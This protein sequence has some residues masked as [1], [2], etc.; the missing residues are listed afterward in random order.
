MKNLILSIF[1]YLTFFAYAQTISPI[2]F[3]FNK[4]S[5]FFSGQWWLVWVIY[6]GLDSLDLSRSARRSST[7]LLALTGRYLNY[8]NHF[9]RAPKGYAGSPMSLVGEWGAIW[10]GRNIVAIVVNSIFRV[11]V[12]FRARSWNIYSHWLHRST[13]IFSV[14]VLIR[15]IRGQSISRDLQKIQRTSAA[16]R[17]LYF[18]QLTL[19]KNP[20]APRFFLYI[21]DTYPIHTRYIPD[22]YVY[23]MNTPWIF[24]EYPTER[25]SIGEMMRFGSIY[26]N[27][28]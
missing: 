12:S 2:V 13:L 8:L 17:H 3:V 9:P 15:D 22:T 28:W 1:G 24:Y 19:S 14:S 11:S 25:S 23:S 26:G 7:I 5:S 10:F 21:P 16:S 20:L 18:I 6:I 4:C 27:R